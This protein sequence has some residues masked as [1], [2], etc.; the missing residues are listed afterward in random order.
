MK[1]VLNCISHLTFATLWL[2]HKDGAQGGGTAPPHG[3]AA[4]LSSDALPSPGGSASASPP[5]PA[6]A[7]SLGESSLPD[8][9][10]G[11]LTH[12]LVA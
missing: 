9:C 7:Q 5:A 4:A 8:A 12:A 2:P 10:M 11:A 3:A 1:S 6:L